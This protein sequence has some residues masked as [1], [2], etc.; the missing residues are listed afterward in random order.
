MS[1]H[2]QLQNSLVAMIDL[3]AFGRSIIVDGKTVVAIFSTPVKESP[4]LKESVGVDGVFKESR[5]LYCK[6]A[7]VDAPVVGQEMIIDG[8]RWIVESVDTWSD[9]FEAECSRYLS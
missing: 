1:F 6:T 9:F 3:N 5:T 8:G 4:L 7:E 2:S